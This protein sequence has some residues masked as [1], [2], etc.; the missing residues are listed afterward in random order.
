MLE[1]SGSSPQ[2]LSNEQVKKRRRRFGP[3]RLKQAKRRSVWALLGAQFKSLIILLLS[4][5]A[6]VSFLFGQWVEGVAIA[7]VIVIN[8]AIG[9]VTELQ[10]V[11]SMEALRRLSK[12]NARVRREGRVAEIPAEEL[13]PGDMA[14]V[15]AGDIVTA[16]LRLVEASKLRADESAL[17]GESVPV[18]KSVDP[19]DEDAPLADRASMLFK[20]T[21]VTRGSGGGWWWPP[22]RPPSWARSPPWWRRPRRRSLRWSDASTG[23]ATG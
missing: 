4:A 2:G 17:T 11:R 16:D 1:E 19:V 22:A 3:N 23:W 6:V 12:V 21:A 15:E 10:A 5:A 18:G 9:F 20:G 14:M 13:V 8:G 7:A